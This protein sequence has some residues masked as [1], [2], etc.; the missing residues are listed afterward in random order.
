MDAV[1]DLGDPLFSIWRIGW[2]YRQLLGDPRGLFDANIFYPT[3]LTFAYSDA[4]L[5]PALAAAPLLAAGVHP[6]LTY[7]ILLVASFY[8]SAV[9]TYLLVRELTESR[10]AAFIAGL[11]FAF[12]PF[13]FEHYSHLELQM[14]F[15]MPLALLALH[16]FATTA[17]LGWAVVA[18]AFAVAQLYSSLYLSLFF[19]CYVLILIAGWAIGRRAQIATWIPGAVLAS[20]VLVVF[21]LPLSR[22]YS[23]T[24]EL[25]R[26]R[27][28]SEVAQYSATRIDYLRAQR[29]SIT[30]AHRTPPGRMEERQ[31][32]PG[33]VAPTLAGVGLFSAGPVGFAYAGALV[34]SYEA[35][36]G[37]NG[38]VFPLLAKLAPFRRIRVPARFSLLVGL[39][40]AVLTGYGVRRLL[41]HAAPRRVVLTLSVLAV[42]VAIDFRSTLK[43]QALWPMPPG[44]YASLPEDAVL[45]EVPAVGE[46]GQFSSLPYMYFSVWHGR[47]MI[48][49]HSGYF[50]AWYLTVADAIDTLALPNSLQ[51]IREQGATHVT[52][53]CALF[54]VGGYPDRCNRLITALED[55]TDLQML[56]RS[57][58][59][60]D[61]VVLYRI[62]R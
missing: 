42:A 57:R 7:N 22:P 16:R 34:F 46:R 19:G 61:D 23:A 48:N 56:A 53:N 49:G 10:A 30:W 26:G 27:D 55:V 47:S 21:G 14:A 60:G 51:R 20:A 33:V 18:A 32:F 24:P 31:L 43:L 44:F 52:V 5:V 41:R 28:P 40:L 29:R 58:W 12:Y 35:S 45:A 8:L 1:P 25:A 17:R 37:P 15:W 59:E 4:M 39:S 2:V 50:P 38:F 54:R 62:A 3:P 36:H 11:V 9:A 13:R 6:V